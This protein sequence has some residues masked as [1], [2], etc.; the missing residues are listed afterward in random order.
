MLKDLEL[1]FR[2]LFDPKI[3]FYLSVFSETYQS[4]YRTYFFLKRYLKSCKL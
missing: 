3:E 2:G 1:I 4:I